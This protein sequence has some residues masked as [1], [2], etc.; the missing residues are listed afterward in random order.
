MEV[1]VETEEMDLPEQTTSVVLVV[2]EVQEVQVQLV[3][4]LLYKLEDSLVKIF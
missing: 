1:L 2:P 3:L 4:L